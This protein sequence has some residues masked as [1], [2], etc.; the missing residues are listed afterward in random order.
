MSSHANE[1]NNLH[2]KVGFLLAPDFTLLAFTGFMEVLR[3]AADVGDGS[4]QIWSSWTVMS[5]DLAPIRASCGVEINPQENFRDPA[6]FDYIVLVGGLL[7][8]QGEVTSELKNYLKQ[9]VR[10]KTKV[11]G[12]CT[13]SFILADIGLLD[14][15][16]CAVHWYHY[17]HFK[18]SYPK[19]LPVI[20]NLFVEDGSI[21][22]SPGGV[23]TTDL[24]LFL[25]ENYF[26]PEKV[27]KVLRHMILDWNRP[28]NHPQTPYINDYSDI[29]DPRMRRAIFYMEQ[30][31][32]NN[33]NIDHVAEEVAIS[34]RQLER[35]F[36]IYLRDSPANYFRTLR[37]RHANWLIHNTKNTI[38]DIAHECGFSDSSHFAKRFKS[39]FGFS[40][41]R[42]RADAE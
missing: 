10:I 3:Q 39:F 16:A 34:T 8:S 19:T 37:L 28:V 26:G 18:A 21:I 5:H 11:I 17:P 40:P 23:A 1:T 31:L 36:Q 27:L 9:A 2:L 6:E 15:R 30:N 35:L 32:S 41:S 29:A 14:D 24:A 25:V 38:T 20:N 13:A 42:A 4:R 12:L 22:T 33:I 7:S